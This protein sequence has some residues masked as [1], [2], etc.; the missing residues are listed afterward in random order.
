MSIERTARDVAALPGSS[1]FRS[2]VRPPP[3]TSQTTFA[4][5]SFSLH[6]DT[7]GNIHGPGNKRAYRPTRRR[8][9]KA[10]A[11]TTTRRVL[12][13]PKRTTRQE[14]KEAFKKDPWVLRAYPK[15]VVCLGCLKTLLLDPDYDYYSQ[16]WQRHKAGCAE[17]KKANH[18]VLDTQQL[19]SSASLNKI[20]CPLTV[21]E[22]TNRH[23]Q[24]LANEPNFIQHNTSSDDDDEGAGPSYL[25]GGSGS[26]P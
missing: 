14:R 26:A 2:T 22:L 11:Q 25:A 9:H 19:T 15:S 20:L 21:D 1:K 4:F 3:P 23:R 7:E 24:R 5:G 10:A 6:E 12:H 18:L 8:A 13:N 17:I 16:P